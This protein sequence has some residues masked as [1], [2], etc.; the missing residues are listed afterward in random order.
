MVTKENFLSLLLGVDVSLFKRNV[1]SAAKKKL[2][3]LNRLD[4]L[5]KS[6][7]HQVS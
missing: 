6:W 1:L 2:N 7:E 5:W 4:L 3:T